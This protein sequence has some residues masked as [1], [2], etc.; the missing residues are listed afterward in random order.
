MTVESV[1]RLVDTI[2]QEDRLDVTKIFIAN[3]LTVEQY[4]S[5][6]VWL[7]HAER[8]KALERPF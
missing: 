7:L 1:A 4:E 8:N 6:L 3:H 2:P 5:L